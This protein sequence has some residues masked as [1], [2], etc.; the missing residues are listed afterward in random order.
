MSDS[1]CILISIKTTPYTSC[2]VMPHSGERV[3]SSL[4]VKRG[5][6]SI[7]TCIWCHYKWI[8][9]FFAMCTPIRIFHLFCFSIE[10]LADTGI[11]LTI[12]CA[13]CFVPAGYVIYLINERVNNEKRMQ[14]I[15]GVGIFMYWVSAVMW[16]LVGI[17]AWFIWVTFTLIDRKIV[18]YTW[19]E[20]LNNTDK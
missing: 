17:L 4:L 3:Q 19:Q 10:S 14:H 8:N 12:L 11:A 2:F 16:D 13:F 20:K 7:S 15:G 6:S 5:W 9:C 18:H 1:V